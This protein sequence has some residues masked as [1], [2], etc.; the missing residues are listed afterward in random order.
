[1]VAGMSSKPKT[2]Q[3]G[4]LPVS[5]ALQNFVEFLLV[6]HLDALAADN[7]A[8][9]REWD[10]PLMRLFAH[11][12]E[13]DLLQMTRAGLTAF[14]GD[15]AS[16]QALDTAA[17]SLKDW[18]ADRLPG[19]PKG[20]IEPED[21]ILIAAAQEQAILGYLTRFTDQ[22]SVAMG[23]VRELRTFYVRTQRDSFDLFTRLREE[24][25]RRALQLESERNAATAS[26]EEFQ[27][28]NEELSAQQEELQQVYEQLK[29][30]NEQVEIEVARRTERLQA[31]NEELASQAEELAA[32][33][34]TI[35]TANSLLQQQAEKMA[36][37]KNFIENLVLN[38]PTGIAYMDIN[39]VFEWV[40]PEFASFANVPVE[41]F[42][43]RSFYDVYPNVEKPNP[44]LA[45]AIESK[46]MSRV[47]GLPLI[48]PLNGSMTY[49]DIVYVPVLDGAGNVNGLMM[50]ALEATTRVRNEQLQ[51]NQID[52]LQQV[53]RMKD[54]F[55]SILSHELRTP[56]NA[57][58][59]F[60]SILDDEIPGPLNELQHLYARRI[61]SGSDVL[62]GLI[63]DLLD[64]SR[65]QAGKFSLSVHMMDISRTIDAAV[66]TLGHLAERKH[67][68]IT[69]ESAS[70]L[71]KILAD[72]QRVGQIFIN[73]VGNAIKFGPE[74]DSIEV[75]VWTDA[76]FVHCEIEDHG[77]GIPE[78]DIER[79]F[80][81]FTQLDSGNTRK[82]GGTG[83]GLSIVKALV[84]AHGGE[85]GVRSAPGTS[86]VFWFTLPVATA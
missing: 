59:G 77:E 25:T 24:A 41:F 9:V 44:R 30:H 74:G 13:P 31:A 19:V 16:N 43:N 64:M 55:L 45:A 51:Q 29:E 66:D 39:H 27:A 18:E 82:A 57:I 47:T 20:S 37:E 81:R 40:N 54:E 83:L 76:G 22:S 6:H 2:A 3:Q 75:R 26:A 80:Q 4:V 11:I 53:D 36:W 14:L 69:V 49:W 65:I 15:L 1:M 33:H 73:L 28:I 8:L 79:L 32:Q 17:Q 61:L 52:Q 68:T 70:P 84:T 58:T 10:V 12:S 48:S 60:A 7:I 71:P 46:Q 38:A 50:M 72:S 21:L 42:V 34:E 23:I 67:Q 56:V 86:T 78:A 35:V 5:E 62:L 63:D 85:V